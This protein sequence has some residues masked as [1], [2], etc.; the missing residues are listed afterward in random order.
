MIVLMVDGL[1][2]QVSERLH[3]I[4]CEAPIIVLNK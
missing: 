4:W 3:P 2:H 1:T